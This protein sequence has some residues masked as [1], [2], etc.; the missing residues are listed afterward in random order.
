M[1]EPLHS[2]KSHSPVSAARR[3]LRWVVG[4]AIGLHEEPAAARRLLDDI[5][6]NLTDMALITRSHAGPDVLL[7]LRLELLGLDAADIADASPETYRGLVSACTSCRFWRRC[8][9]DL[10]GGAIPHGH[11]YCGNRR[12]LDRLL[13]ERQA[14]LARPK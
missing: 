10:S 11:D 1:L 8:A 6:K 14:D 12:R 3:L 7:P 5:D 4:G 9:R 2:A 13:L